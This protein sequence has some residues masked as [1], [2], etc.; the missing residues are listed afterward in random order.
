MVNVL[1]PKCDPRHT[2]WRGAA[3]LAA[4]DSTAS[5]RDLWLQRRQ[6]AVG[7]AGGG[8]AG[9]P[10]GRAASAAN[11]HARLFGSLR[12]QQGA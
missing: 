3:L 2:A 7:E 8:E 11:R 1:E 9:A 4:L 10:P 5:G 6:W 12:S